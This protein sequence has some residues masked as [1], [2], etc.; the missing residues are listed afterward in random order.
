[1]LGFALNVNAA[2]A[3]RQRPGSTRLAGHVPTK[4]VQ[5]SVF[6]NRV[7][8]NTQVP[9]TFVLP[10]RNQDELAE[11]IERLHNPTD[12][13]YGKYLTTAEFVARYA[14]AQEDH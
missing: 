14:P 1:M 8:G 10:L 6:L 2:P 13:L 12:E 11:L 9:I 7:D 3:G 4:A 5:K